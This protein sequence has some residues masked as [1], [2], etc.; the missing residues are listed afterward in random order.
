MEEQNN[1]QIFSER[2]YNP[3]I[4]DTQLSSKFGFFKKISTENMYVTVDDM[5]KEETPK[6]E[7]D[8]R[9]DVEEQSQDYIRNLSEIESISG[10]EIF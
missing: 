7:E 4:L 1:K 5:N 2:V 8:I 10:G 3:K 6:D 9:A